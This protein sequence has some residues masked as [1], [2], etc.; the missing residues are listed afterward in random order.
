MTIEC[1]H[2]CPSTLEVLIARNGKEGVGRNVGMLDIVIVMDEGTSSR[3]CDKKRSHFSIWALSL[4]ELNLWIWK[5]CL[6]IS[7][8]NHWIGL[9]LMLLIKIGIM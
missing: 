3:A 6:H 7:G 2:N 4:K 5:I 8:K 1:Q 9:I